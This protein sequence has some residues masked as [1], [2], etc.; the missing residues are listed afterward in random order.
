MQP[1]PWEMCEQERAPRPPSGL[2]ILA[3]GPAAMVPQGLRAQLRKDPAERVSPSLPS[4]PPLT[5][6]RGSW[7]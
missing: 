6:E 1:P 7:W 4:N 5:V 2:G 3:A